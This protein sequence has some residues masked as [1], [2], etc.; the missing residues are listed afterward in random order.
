MSYTKYSHESE[1]Q[2]MLGKIY[3]YQSRMEDQYEGEELGKMVGSYAKSIGFKS[4]KDVMT[5]NMIR[6]LEMLPSLNS[7]DDWCRL[8]IAKYC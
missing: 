6:A 8:Y 2:A 7:D 3:A 4:S 5:R 1:R